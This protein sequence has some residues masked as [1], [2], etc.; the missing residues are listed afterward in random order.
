MGNVFVVSRSYQHCTARKP[1][2]CS[3]VLSN[4]AALLDELGDWTVFLGKDS[5]LQS[6]VPSTYHLVSQD[7]TRVFSLIKT[8]FRNPANEDTS[9]Y[10]LTPHHTTNTCGLTIDPPPFVRNPHLYAF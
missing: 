4:V 2:V 9:D 8:G 5:D 10:N 6:Q 3:T 1:G 7:I